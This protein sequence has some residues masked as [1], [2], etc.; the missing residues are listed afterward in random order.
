MQQVES[1]EHKD[2][3]AVQDAVLQT[4]VPHEVVGVEG[5]V[6]VSASAEYGEVRGQSDA[7]WQWY[8]CGQSVVVVPCTDVSEVASVAR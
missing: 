4:G 5:G 6:F 1:I 7:P 2:E 8:A 3:V